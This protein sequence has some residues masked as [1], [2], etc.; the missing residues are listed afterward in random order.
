MG[1]EEVTKKITE[2]HWGEWWAVHQK[3]TGDH[4]QKGRGVYEKNWQ[5]EGAHKGNNYSKDQLLW[6]VR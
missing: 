2:D 4:N 1:E 5:T 6:E 3:I